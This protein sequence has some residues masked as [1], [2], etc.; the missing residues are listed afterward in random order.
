MK[1][2][3]M[4]AVAALFAFG[5]AHAADVVVA[6]DGDADG[7][8]TVEEWTTARGSM[9]GLFGEWDTDGDNMLSRSEYD[10][11]IG[12]HAEADKFGTWDDRYGAWDEDA[13]EMLSADEYNMGLWTQ[14]DSD[15]SGFWS[16]DEIT[17]WEEDEMRYDATRS[18]RQVS[19]PD[20][21]TGS[22]AGAAAGA[23]AGTGTG[24]TGGAGGT[25]GVKN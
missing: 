14:F 10:A 9:E 19:S 17:A 24:G 15:E 3:M 25:G 22:E 13:D 11:A 8:V 12:A 16:Q 5:S 21:S 2:T 1:T 6:I 20:A 7:Q 23:S 4:T 18:G